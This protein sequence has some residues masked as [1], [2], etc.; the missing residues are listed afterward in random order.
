MKEK[1]LCETCIVR[2]KA[3]FAVLA[4]KDLVNLAY[5]KSCY[6]YKKG[7]LIF[8]EE[9]RAVGVYCLHNG[10]VK[11]SKLGEEGREQIIRFIVPGELFGIRALVGAQNYSVNAT[12]LEDSTI[13]FINF[14]MFSDLAYKYPEISKNI[15]LA[16]SN[17]LLDAENKM[18]SLAQKP[19]RERL[20]ESLLYL[21]QSLENEMI[22]SKH[23]NNTVI[24]LSREDIANIVGSATETVIRLISEF[25]E[26]GLIQ[27]KGRKIYI[28]DTQ[29]MSDIAHNIL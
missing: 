7:Q 27:V 25:K 11:I 24:N 13:C 20:A 12:A 22:E 18:T 28:L 15:I 9:N 6:F 3:Y 17:R 21:S 10:K 29:K 19:V 14:S 8:H 16:L 5:H 4:E 2:A 26:E 23:P 1:P